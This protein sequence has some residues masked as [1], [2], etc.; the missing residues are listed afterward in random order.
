VSGAQTSN[1]TPAAVY[2]PPG[3]PIGDDLRQVVGA[4]QFES[5]H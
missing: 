5:C 1:G 2:F 3:S 4:V